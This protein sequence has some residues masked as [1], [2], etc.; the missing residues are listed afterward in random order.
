MAT[1]TLP[2]RETTMP[3]RQAAL[4]SASRVEQKGN[5]FVRWITSTDHKVIGYMYLIASVLFFM[6]GGVMAANMP[7]NIT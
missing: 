3:P 7:M 6:I 1:Q 4:L 5:I 2:P